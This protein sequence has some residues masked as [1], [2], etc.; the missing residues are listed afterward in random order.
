MIL[1]T[2][3]GRSEQARKAPDEPREAMRNSFLFR[4]CHPTSDSVNRVALVQ[5]PVDIERNA[6]FRNGEHDVDAVNVPRVKKSVA[7]AGQLPRLLDKRALQGE[8]VGGQP[9]L[10]SALFGGNDLQDG[11]CVVRR[12]QI[13]RHLL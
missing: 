2:K 4:E 3:Q 12:K 8:L 10:P 11:V 7:K 5:L 9:D 1:L 6:H 13:M